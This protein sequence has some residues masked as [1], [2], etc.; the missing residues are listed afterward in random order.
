MK[1][2]VIINGVDPAL[3]KALENE[4]EDSRE[5]NAALKG[6]VLQLNIEIRFLRKEN[7]KLKQK[8]KACQINP[9]FDDAYKP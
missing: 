7:A 9:F 4:L 2:T 5:N 1:G 6:L 3:Y 8:T